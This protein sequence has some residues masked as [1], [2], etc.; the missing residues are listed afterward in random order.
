MGLSGFSPSLMKLLLAGEPL[1]EEEEEIVMVDENGA[2]AKKGKK[3]PYF[4]VRKALDS[5][6][7]DAVRECLYASEEGVL[8]KYVP[9]EKEEKEEKVET[10]ETSMQ[11]DEDEWEEVENA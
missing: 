3:D 1:E 2:V 4:T 11:I 10:G 8:K 7:Y 9:A 5:E 6:D